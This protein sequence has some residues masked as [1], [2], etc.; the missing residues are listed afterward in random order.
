MVPGSLNA[1]MDTWCCTCVAAHTVPYTADQQD[2]TQTRSLATTDTKTRR[3]TAAGRAIS[4]CRVSR[5][6][7]DSRGGAPASSRMPSG[8]VLVVARERV[9]VVPYLLIRHAR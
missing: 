9:P 3:H 2:A 7:T 8:S 6:L 4:A 5:L 1:V